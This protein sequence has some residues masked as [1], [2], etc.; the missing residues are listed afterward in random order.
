MQNEG[1]SSIELK[2]P[3]LRL[4]NSYMKKH[5]VEFAAV[6]DGK[7]K[8]T[9]FFKGKDV[10]CV[11]HAFDQYAKKLLK[12]GKE[13]QPIKSTLEDAKKIAQELNVGRDKVKN[14]SKGGLER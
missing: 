2:N 8:Y 9:L 13:K 6:K 14:R 5:G 12:R 7:D 11:K 4:L 3:D 1:L 10:D